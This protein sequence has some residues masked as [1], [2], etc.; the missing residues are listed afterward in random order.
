MY[1]KWGHGITEG[2]IQIGC[3]QKTIEEWDLFFNSEDEL[4]TKRG[5]QEFKQIQAVFEA[6]KAYLNFLNDGK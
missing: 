5:T 2:E 1:C 4:E 3:K 6:Y